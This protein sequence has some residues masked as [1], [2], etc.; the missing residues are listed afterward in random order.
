MLSIRSRLAKNGPHEIVHDLLR[1]RRWAVGALSAQH[2]PETAEIEGISFE[3]WRLFLSLE[4]CAAVLLDCVTRDG[5]TSRVDATGLDALR[6]VAATEMQ[7]SMRARVDGREMAV[8]AERLSFPVIVLK[9]GVGAITGTGPTLPVG[10][11]DILVPP[12]HVADMVQVLTSA[13]FGEP[14]LDLDH[15]HA[16]A[17]ADERLRIEVHW[18]SH[19]DGSPLDA[20]VWTRIRDLESTT[21]LKQLGERD[22]LVSLVEHAI[23]THRERSPSL[24]DTL[25]IGNAAVRCTDSELTEA[26]K[27][28][29]YN[30]SM[31]ALLEFAI[32][33][34][35]GTPKA[36]PF[37]IGSAA[38]YSAVVLA[39]ELPR[40]LSS[41]GALAFITALDVARVP[42]KNTLKRTAKWRGTGMQGVGG[43]TRRFPQ[44]GKLFVAPLRLTYYS[45]V[46]AVVI[47]VLRRTRRKALSSL[48][49]PRSPR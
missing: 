38:F 40:P 25:L 11:I 39:D 26:R 5:A 17:P 4:R 1:L 21:P 31:K 22:N 19:D 35:L 12:E 10:D 33:V 15:H 18:T 36:D 20:A 49:T 32:Q 24:R 30:D 14:T 2:N 23:D 16:L 28:L 13:G 42:R 6:K 7:S 34:H 44:I 46:A 43:V 48:E 3:T 29:A 9:G 27:D 47:P 8:I 41:Q 37:L 45:L